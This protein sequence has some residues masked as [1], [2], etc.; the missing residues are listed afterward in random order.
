[1]PTD[2]STGPPASPGHR[3]RTN[4]TP[5]VCFVALFVALLALGLAGWALLRPPSTNSS[6]EETAVTDAQRSDA[7]AK[8]CSAFDIVRNGVNR[9][10]N[11]QAPGG[12]TDL[13]GTLAVAANARLSLSNGGQYLLTNLTSATPAELANSVRRF[14]N[15]LM[16]IGA[17]ATAGAQNAEPQQA[18]R[19]REASETDAT[20]TQLCS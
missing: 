14:A 5:A 13:A 12:S 17:Y 8:I 15:V 18:A 4:R 20:I 10:T 1:M 19:L 6:P 16:D 9:N 3:Q 11:L 2:T 7:Q